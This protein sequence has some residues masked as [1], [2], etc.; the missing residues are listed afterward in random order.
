M[1]R[2]RRAARAHGTFRL[3]RTPLLG[4]L[5]LLGTFAALG[6]SRP[7]PSHRFDNPLLNEVVRMTQAEVPDATILAFLRSRRVRLESDVSAQDLIELHREGVADEIIEYV[8]A[9][10]G[11][12]VPPA[13]SKPGE[14][15]PEAAAPAGAGG[16]SPAPVPVDP[17]PADEPVPQGSDPGDTGLIMGV[18]DPIPV[19]GYPCWPAFLAPWDCGDRGLVVG[20][21]PGWR[22][23]DF[24]G[25]GRRMS[26]DKERTADGNG[27]RQADPG[28]RARGGRDGD[29]DRSG[30]R[31]R[32]G[33]GMNS[34]GGYGRSRPGS[35]SERGDGRSGISS[36]GRSDGAESGGRGNSSGSGAS[37]GGSSRSGAS[38]SGGRSSGGG[39]GRH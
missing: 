12:D 30:D 24:R 23:R 6:D 37:S 22:G 15:G 8:A 38:S 7:S 5:C 11:M 4:A 19:D 14:A 21:G 13:A 26:R 20:G 18:Y 32:G 25:E 34:G 33:D 36:P 1:K 9:Q 2:A 28:G 29:R 27:G 16:S 35:E 31:D 10:S 17:E 39:R 3:L